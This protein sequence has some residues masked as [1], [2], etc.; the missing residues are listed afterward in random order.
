[1]Q[2]RTDSADLYVGGSFDPPHLGHL[3]A[4]QEALHR[5]G[6]TRALFVPTG[7]N[8]LKKNREGTAPEDRLEMLRRAVAGNDAFSLSEVEIHSR[9]VSYTVDTIHHLITTG[10][11]AGLDGGRPGMMIGDDL[12]EQLPRW[13]EVTKL[14]SIVSLV[15][16]ARDAAFTVPEIVPPE[17]MIIRNLPIPIS[18]R[19]IRQRL[20]EGAPIRY[21]VPDGVYEYIEQK[22]LYR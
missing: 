20:R 15:V 8:P 21:L 2:S 4:A 17:A 7:R 11:L 13:R 12:L 5:G 16:V 14:L 3:Y 10:Q 1:M 22:H 6:F 19:E 18:S 9:D